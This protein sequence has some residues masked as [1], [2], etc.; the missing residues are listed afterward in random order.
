MPSASSDHE[1][2]PSLDLFYLCSCAESKD[3][4][5]EFEHWTDLQAAQRQLKSAEDHLKKMEDRA[6]SMEM[7]NKEA[8]SNKCSSKDFCNFICLEQNSF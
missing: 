7:N 4:Q 6:E 3:I 1:F 5:Q 8:V 2:W